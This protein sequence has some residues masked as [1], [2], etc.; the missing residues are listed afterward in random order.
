MEE[1]EDFFVQQGYHALFIKHDEK[2][3]QH[4]VG[5]FLL[6]TMMPGLNME[7]VEVGENGKP[8]IKGSK[9]DF[10]ISHSGDLVT[11][12]VAMERRVGV[13]VEEIND[14]ILRV[15][16]KFMSEKDEEAFQST[17]F[18]NTERATICWTVKEA[19]YKLQG[20][21][22]VDFKRDIRL[23]Q[24]R[25]TSEGW[26]GELEFGHQ[27]SKILICKGFKKNNAC[28]SVVEDALK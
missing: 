26:E 4:L 27:E 20:K 19:V 9:A 2:R 21:S 28:I 24:I 6:R 8:F 16:H 7:S 14:R 11:V 25:R 5:R 12:L 1:E 23:V 15:Q 22:G 3:K 18:T 10:S 13:D 17:A